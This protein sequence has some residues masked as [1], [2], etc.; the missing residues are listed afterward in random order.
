MKTYAYKQDNKYFLE[1]R[2]EGFDLSKFEVVGSPTITDDGVASGFS[3]GNYL[4]IPINI[5]VTNKEFEINLGKQLIPLS[6]ITSSYMISGQQN[7]Q[8]LFSMGISNGKIFAGCNGIYFNGILPN[9]Q[10]QTNTYY[11]IKGGVKNNLAYLMIST[12]GKN[13]T[14]YTDTLTN[15]YTRLSLRV[16]YS[17][18]NIPSFAYNGSID[19]K[20]ISITVDGKEIF[21]GQNDKYYA[22]RR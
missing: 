2:K 21:N 5:D 10:L 14:T 3:N 19:L 20:Q 15:T 12:D 13:Y 9:Y 6:F 1:H 11:W 7:K 4:D 22:L 16:G 17:G 18:D 8:D